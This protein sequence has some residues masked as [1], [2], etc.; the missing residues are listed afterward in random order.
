MGD[1]F[2]TAKNL[3]Q[4]VYFSQITQARAVKA[5]VEHLRVHNFRNHGVLF[6]QFN[7]CCPAI[8][9]SAI[10]A[11]YEPKALC[12]YARRFFS[13]L[14]ITVVPELE[15]AQAGLPPALQPLN[16]IVINDSNLPITA[17][18]NCRLLDLFGSLL[19]QVATPVVIAP[20]STSVL[21]KLPK[22]TIF[23]TRPDKSA[24]HLLMEKDGKKIA[25]NL[26]LYL[27]DKYI[28]WPEAKIT[29]LFSQT[30]DKQ[31][32]LKLKSNAIAKDVQISTSVAAQ[33]SDNF[34]DLIPPNEFE[35]TI[36]CEQQV[37]SIESVLQ[38]RSLNKLVY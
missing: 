11:T 37:S 17:T 38:L 19:D 14:L 15:K 35:I 21:P 30:T 24:L 31:W 26:F 32:K 7:D 4:F 33:F 2:G 6:W 1:L 20:F 16:V 36:D 3:E 12:Y 25:E 8:S 10:D 29:K 13:K 18:L 23:P 27:P 5:Y 22:E 34:I 9:W 28:D